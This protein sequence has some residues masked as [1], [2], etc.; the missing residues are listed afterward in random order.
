MEQE[1]NGKPDLSRQSFWDIDMNNLDFDRYAD[2]TIVRVLERGS[3]KDVRE[4]IRYYGEGKITD[5]V[6]AASALLPRAIL[7]SKQLFNIPNDR[8]QCLKRSQRAMN[9]SM[10]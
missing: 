9:Y 4:L 10:Y 2:F 1:K 8:F 6:I 3:E 7:V 5:V